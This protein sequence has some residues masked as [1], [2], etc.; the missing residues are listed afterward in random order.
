MFTHPDFDVYGLDELPVDRDCYLMDEIYLEDY[1]KQ[2]LRVFSGSAYEMPIG[3]ISHVAVRA[4]D[5]ASLE[6]SWYLVHER[7]HEIRVVLPKPEIIT[8]IGSWKWDEKPHIFVKTT[9]LNDLHLQSYSVFGFID[10]IGVKKAIKD[11][12]ITEKRLVALRDEIDELGKS[13]P[14]VSFISFADSVLVKSNWSVGM[15]NSDVKYTYKP[16]IFLITIKELQRIFEKTLGL[17]I[18][19]VLTQGYNE[20]YNDSLLHI[21]S[22]QN[23]VC[24]NS[25]GL[26]FA[27]LLAIDNAVKGNIRKKA[28]RPSE[29]YMDEYFFRSLRCKE[30]LIY[31]FPDPCYGWPSTQ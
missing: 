25:L 23:H 26:P 2:M 20:Y 30:G 13:Y 16:E 10:A 22:S 5:P 9:W 27:Q 8:C 17:A 18:Y 3:Y 19:A 1:E 12:A 7:F 15:V 29:V 31:S 11:G 21:S 4:I 14:Q 24:L 6:L 28:H